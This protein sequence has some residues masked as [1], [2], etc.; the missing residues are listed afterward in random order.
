[1]VGHIIPQVHI[2]DPIQVWVKTQAGQGYI[3]DPLMLC[4]MLDVHMTTKVY[5]N[6][7]LVVEV[8]QPG[9][10]CNLVASYKEL[11]VGKYILV[12]DANDPHIHI[13]GFS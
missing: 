1:M 4:H 8:Y 3:V 11:V 2:Q 10:I 13:L 6:I 5:P 7:I 9:T 12:A